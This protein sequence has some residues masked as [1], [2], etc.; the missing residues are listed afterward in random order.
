MTF[1]FLIGLRLLVAISPSFLEIVIL[2]L[3]NVAVLLLQRGGVDGVLESA[4]SGLV[5][6][7]GFRDVEFG[8][9]DLTSLCGPFD[10]LGIQVLVQN[11]LIKT[12]P[13]LEM[14]LV[15][16]MPFMLFWIFSQL[17]LVVQFLRP[18]GIDIL[19]THILLLEQLLQNGAL[20]PDFRI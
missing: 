8:F 16:K 11:G 17:L 4:Q 1:D 18:E 19:K 13:E 2:L 3:E 9:L 10:V 7:Y 5:L 20:I 15:L 6:G 14:L 12:I